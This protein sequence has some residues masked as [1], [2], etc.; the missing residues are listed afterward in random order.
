MAR[1]SIIR[2]MSAVTLAAAF[3]SLPTPA[4]AHGDA[5][6]PGTSWWSLWQWSP[7]ILIALGLVLAVYWRG[8]RR[9]P[10]PPTAHVAA[11]LGGL[12]AFFAAL[13]SPIEPLADHIFAVHQVEHM[14]LRTLGPMLVFAALPQAVLLRGLPAGWR[15][16]LAGSVGGN[17]VVR[18]VF[19]VLTLPAVATGLFLFA[20]YFWMVPHWHDLAIL[21]RPVHYLWHLSLL[22]TG[23]IFFSVIFDRRRPPAGPSLGARLA[24]FVVAAL[25]NVVLG[26]FLTFKS[27]PLYDAYARIGHLWPVPMV[28]DEETGGAI[29]WMPGCM[30]FAAAAGIMLYRWGQDEA[31]REAQRRRDGRPVAARA[32]RANGRLAFGLAG[33]ALA[34]LLIAVTA[35]VTVHRM[36]EYHVLARAHVIP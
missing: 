14:L 21:D 3:A 19:G 16:R 26:A 17:R 8:L 13:I 7:E 24:M 6:H 33:F 28:L 36:D 5:I 32:V 35:A 22:V 25:G 18:G 31:R 4:L 11:F 12:V 30:M 27:V 29:M 34:M 2:A 10:R 15:R 23:V 9:G 1:R 20:S